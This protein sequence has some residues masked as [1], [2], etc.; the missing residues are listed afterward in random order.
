[1]IGGLVNLFFYYA[2]ESVKNL[3]LRHAGDPVEVAEIMANW[4]RVLTP[5]LGG[6]A[7]GLRLLL[8]V[9]FGGSATFQ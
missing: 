4:Q 9:A 8:G 3:F 2:T 6:L 5:T 7:A 1:M